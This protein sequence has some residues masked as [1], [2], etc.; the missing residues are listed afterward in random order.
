MKIWLTQIGEILPLQANIRMMRVG[1]LAERL[2]LRGHDVV[3]WASAFDHMQKKMLF[4]EDREIETRP[5]LKI[6]ALTSRGYKKNISLSRCLDHLL[7]AEKMAKSFRC[8]APP[9]IIVASMPDHWTAYQAVKYAK[10]MNIPVLVDVRDEWPDV[11]LNLV[12]PMF[13]PFM[14]HILIAEYQKVSY[15]LRN[16]TGILS[17]MQYMMQWALDKAGRMETWKDRVFYLGSRYANKS[18]NA[19]VPEKFMKVAHR[20]N[21]QCV[22][23]FIGTMGSYYNPRIL[24]KVA[25]M[26][27]DKDKVFFIIAG[28]GLHFDELHKYSRDCDNVFMPGWLSEPE[29]QYL[30]SISHIGVIPCTESIQTFPNKAYTYL[31][32]GLPILSSVEGELGK[33]I[34]EKQCGFTYP[35]GDQESL[36]VLIDKLVMDADL[37]M[38]MAQRA[39]KV[40]KDHYDADIIYNEFAEHVENIAR[41]Q[42]KTLN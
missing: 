22:V 37:R 17:M 19:P 15:L 40:F 16:A 1:Y 6:R 11:F 39:A 32:A 20:L 5:G 8:S 42:Q 29:I 4:P 30:L 41:E 26:M 7:L 2:N 10:R 33:L 9:D 28:N 23:T 35:V 21:G 18:P 25:K 13:R 3:W 36:A 34:A 24:V 38:A 12:S 27:G 31:S 14:R